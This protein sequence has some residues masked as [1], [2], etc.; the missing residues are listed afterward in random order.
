[1][2]LNQTIDKLQALGLGAMAAALADQAATPGTRR[3]WRPGS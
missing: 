2:L 3:R 1:M